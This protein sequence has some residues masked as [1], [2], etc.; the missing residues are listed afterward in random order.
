VKTGLLRE[1]TQPED[2]KVATHL[3]NAI[4]SIKIRITESQPIDRA[5]S[6]SGGIS[7]KELDEK[8]MIT[9]IP[10]VFASGEMLDWDAPTGGY[11]LTACLALGKSA[12]NGTL[13]WLDK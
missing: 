6:S 13:E 12:A 2:L 4:K 9:K 5:I 10:G 7:F 8:L 11:L 3:V 1:F